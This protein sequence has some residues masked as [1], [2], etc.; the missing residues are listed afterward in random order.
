MKCDCKIGHHYD[1]SQVPDWTLSTINR[2]YIEQ[3]EGYDI[4]LKDVFNARKPHFH[5]YNYCHNC[6]TKINWRKIKGEIK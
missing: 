2:R 1:Y 5:R 4:K 3:F 6:G